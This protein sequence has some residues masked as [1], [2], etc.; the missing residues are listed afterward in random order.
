MEES[1]ELDAMI[2][3][4]EIQ[5]WPQPSPIA[6]PQRGNMIQSPEDKAELQTTS[7]DLRDI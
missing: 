4:T 7:K 3:D 2:Q 5:A 6:Y 1:K